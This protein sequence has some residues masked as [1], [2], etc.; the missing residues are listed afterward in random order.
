MGRSVTPRGRIEGWVAEE[1]H[2][3][4]LLDPDSEAAE[5]MASQFRHAGF[6]THVTTTGRS[7]LLATQTM[8][9]GGI[10]VVADLRI[11]ERCSDLI[12]I[13]HAAPRSWLL[14]IADPMSGQAGEFPDALGADAFLTAPFTVA[15]LIRCEL[16]DHA[17]LVRCSIFSRARR[18][19]RE[20]ALFNLPQHAVRCASECPH[21]PVYDECLLVA[22]F[23][24]MLV[25]DI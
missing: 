21:M 15:D 5:V 23:L 3:V 20:I 25:H 9:F 13:R 18:P 16:L 22:L 11:M 8:R 24:S 19:P 2:R 1:S 7:T 14:L 17:A 10:V 4:L 12:Q 6:E